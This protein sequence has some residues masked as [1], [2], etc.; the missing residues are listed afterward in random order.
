MV[1]QIL[2][3]VA[4]A[5]RERILERTNDGQVTAMASGVRFGRKPHPA[6]ASAL[7]L[8]NRGLHLRRYRRKQVY[9]ERHVSG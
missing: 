7:T 2:A 3:A 5:E 9:R 4:E 6:T 1:I 8:L